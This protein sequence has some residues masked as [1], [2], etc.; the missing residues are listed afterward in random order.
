MAWNKTTKLIVSGTVVLLVLAAAITVFLQR[1]Q[2]AHHLMVAGAERAVANHTA[3]PIDLTAQYATPA[4]AFDNGNSY[5]SEVP[6][7]FQVFNHV[8]LQID[9]MMYLWGDGN[10]KMGAKFP[11][12]I[13]G[14]PV[15]QRFETLYVYHCAFFSS[16]AKTPVYE[17]VFRYADG[18]SATNQMLYGTDVLDFNSGRGKKT[19][20]GPTGPNSRLAWLGGSFT[21]DGKQPLR[22]CLT[23]IKNP[24]P[25]HEVTSI[26]L[27]SCKGKSAGVILALTT[28]KDGMM[29]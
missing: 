9:G 19:V 12:E 3:T 23:A 28:G 5:W 13:L 26:E 7:G 27:Y 10:A 1:H 21:P 15:N 25:S 22:F 4:S 29:K 18:S 11:E 16:P 6:W 8:P 17:M 2:I 24:Q 20:A 14:I